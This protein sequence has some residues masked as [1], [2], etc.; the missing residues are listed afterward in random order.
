MKNVIL[1]YA[2]RYA[3]GRKTYAVSE[4]AEEIIH[5]A[6]EMSPNIRTL[7]L[8]ELD[9]AYKE[10]RLGMGIDVKQWMK[11]RF[12]LDSLARKESSGPGVRCD[13][14]TTHRGNRGPLPLRA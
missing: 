13:S 8:Q 3:L 11:V 14:R 9:E 10:N 2:F 1:F 6:E 5:Y 7:M 4:V 12:V